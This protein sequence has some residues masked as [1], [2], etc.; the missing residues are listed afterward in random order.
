MVTLAHGDSLA[1]ALVVLDGDSH[2]DDLVPELAS[3]DGLG[4]LLVRKRGELILR[5]ARHAIPLGN[6]LRG[7][8]FPNA[9]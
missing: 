9:I 8:M 6:V 5:L 2:G 7:L 4:G 1:V 3:L